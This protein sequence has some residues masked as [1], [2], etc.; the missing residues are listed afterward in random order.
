MAAPY[1]TYQLE[2]KMANSVERSGHRIGIE[3]EQLDCGNYLIHYNEHGP[4]LPSKRCRVS[5]KEKEIP[6]L[7]AK[8]IKAKKK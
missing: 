1:D 5:C 3:V 6:A 7:L 4:Y 2:A 8:L